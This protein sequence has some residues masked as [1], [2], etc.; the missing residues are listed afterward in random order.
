VKVRVLKAEEVKLLDPSGLCF[1]NLN[2]PEEFSQAE[3]IFKRLN[4]E[5]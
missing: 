5:R 4:A 2:T 3:E 1:W